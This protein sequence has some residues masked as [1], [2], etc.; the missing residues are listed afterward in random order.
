VGSARFALFIGTHV[1]SE[2]PF[3]HDSHTFDPSRR[4]FLSLCLQAI[5]FQEIQAKS[6]FPF[7]F[8]YRCVKNRKRQETNFIIILSPPYQSDSL[9]V[10]FQRLK[11]QN[12]IK[13]VKLAASQK[14]V[15]GAKVYYGG[16]GFKYA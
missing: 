16:F 2:F 1:R 9:R 8:A 15:H 6:T 7:L 5:T 11:L 14:G 10:I 4:D 13:I 3:L 12:T